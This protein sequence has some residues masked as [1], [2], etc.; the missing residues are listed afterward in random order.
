[1]EE[2]VE[3]KVKFKDKDLQLFLGSI[4]KNGVFIAL[5]VVVIGLVLYL[6]QEGKQL[7]TFSEF[8]KVDFNFSA[9]FYGLFHGESLSIMAL[10]VILLIL[11]PV[12]RVVFAIIGFHWEND[13]LYT[14]VSIIVLLIIVFSSV[15]GA[16]S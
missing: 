13:R 9:F 14:Y 4:L 11:T 16:V 10:G 12:M 1:M 6:F 8:D 7:T 5:S 15:L 2:V 3:D